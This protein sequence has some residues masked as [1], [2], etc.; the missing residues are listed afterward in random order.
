[1]KEIYVAVH[2][3]LNQGDPVVIITAIRR[4]GSAPRGVGAKMVTTQ[5]KQIFGTIGGGKVE[6]DVLAE[7]HE[8]FQSH[9]N[10][11]KSFDMT[12]EDM[13]LGHMVCGG[14]MGFLLEY[15]SPE[16]DNLSFFDAIKD[17]YNSKQPLLIAAAWGLAEADPVISRGLM[18]ADG[19]IQ[20]DLRL[21]KEAFDVVQNKCSNQKQSGLLA[22][23]SGLCWIE[24]ILDQ[25]KLILFGAG[26]VAVPVAQI[27]Y[28]AG[29]QVL[30]L[31][32]RDEYASAER[33]PP[34]M[35]VKVVKDFDDCM[36]EIDIDDNS[37]LVIVTRA[38]IHDKT[39]LSQALKTNA[40][41]IGMIGSRKKREVIYRALKEEGVSEE[42]LQQ[43]YSPIGLDINAETPEE[44]AVSIMAE[45]IK[46]RAEK[47]RD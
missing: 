29:F 21:D 20:G 44:I 30:A 24:P 13:V 14:R 33:F 43:V 12:H 47:M 6:E 11:L 17:G 22:F 28:L 40:G 8:M 1:M 32:D 39:V 27:A 2:R 25:G 38:H 19:L 18:T 16:E 36:S 34:P 5:G 26:H 37:Y 23:G 7:A 9:D 15:I 4:E 45:L 46:V 42:A 41:Y 3:L 35:A 31:D 10:R